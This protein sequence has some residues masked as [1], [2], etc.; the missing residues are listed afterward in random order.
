M[1]NIILVNKHK[2][3]EIKITAGCFPPVFLSDWH[4]CGVGLLCHSDRHL[5][6]P[7]EQRMEDSASIAAGESVWTHRPITGENIP[8]LLF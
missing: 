5:V 1:I 2:H 4:R 6:G 7:V 8:F 3:C